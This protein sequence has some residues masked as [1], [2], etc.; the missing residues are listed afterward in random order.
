MR[1]QLSG[2]R[3]GK[4]G[5]GRSINRK[6]IITAL[7]IILV[8]I[9]LVV[10]AVAAFNALGGKQLL[11]GTTPTAIPAPVSEATATPTAAPAPTV[12]MA[13]GPAAS[14][15]NSLYMYATLNKTSGKCLVSL[16]L[17]KDA[18]SVDV[19]K[20]GMN[21]LCD[22]QSYSN[23]WSLKPMDWNNANGNTL[24]EPDE[25][26]VATVDTSAKGIPQGKPLT[27]QFMKDGL[28]LQDLTVV[29]S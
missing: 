29:P 21:I 9:V 2:D 5:R 23:L 22:G 1:K 26:I 8:A 3:P 15:S 4:K 7:S 12:T 13:P 14:T 17:L 11:S 6:L 19:S 24:L 27:I 10:V 18:A 25:I 16:K 20:L 28:V